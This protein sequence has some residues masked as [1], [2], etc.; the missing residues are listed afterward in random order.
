AAAAAAATAAA[1]SFLAARHELPRTP[2][3][4]SPRR[5]GGVAVP[6]WAYRELDDHELGEFL[7]TREANITA[8]DES[9]GR[10]R[11]PTRRTNRAS[12]SP[13]GRSPTPPPTRCEG[14]RRRSTS[15]PARLCTAPL[16]NAVLAS[17][18]AFSELPQPWNVRDNSCIRLLGAKIR[19]MQTGLQ[20]NLSAIYG[21][22]DFGLDRF[23]LGQHTALRGAALPQA[24]RCWELPWPSL[25]ALTSRECAP[26]PST[27]ER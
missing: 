4:R 17:A 18:E 27:T 19:D 21:G 25:A 20:S 24:R 16:V 10:G 2:G 15:A 11:H 23:Q 3:P 1:A 26:V 14:C 22:V 7:K 5:A 6:P 9:R 8:K 12:R 13:W